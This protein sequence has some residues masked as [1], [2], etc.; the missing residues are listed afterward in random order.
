M[1][2]RS[3]TMTAIAALMIFQR[4]VYAGPTGGTV[5]AGSA[6]I[7]QSGSTTNVNQSS[8][9]AIINWQTFS[10]GKQETVNFLQPNSSAVA[11]NRVNGNEQSIIS[12]ALNANGRV[13]IVNSAGVLFSKGAQVNVGGLVASTLDISNSDFMAGNYKFSGTSAASVINRGN[14]HAS[15]GGYVALLGKT[16]ANDGVISARLGTVAMAAGEQMTLN[17]GGNSLFDVTIDK[18]TLNA[19][20]ANHRAIKADGGTVIMTAKAADE[21]LSAQV[22][23]TGIVQARTIASLLGG[24]SSNPK[25]HIGKIKIVAD[26]GTANISGKLDASAP[27]GGNGGTIE[28]SGSHVKIADAAIITTKASYGTSGSWLIDPTDFTIAAS[29]GDI[30]GAAL[31][32]QLDNNATVTIASTQGSS[33]TNGDINVNEA[34][35]W[36]SNAILTLNAANNININ[37]PITATGTSAG[38]ALNYGGTNGVVGATPLAGSDYNIVT[39]ASFSGTVLDSAGNPIA[40]PDTSGGVYG[41]ITLSGGSST[42]SVNGTGYTMIRSMADLAAVSSAQNKRLALAMD[43]NAAGTT[44]NYNVVPTLGAGSVFAGLGHTIDGLTIRGTTGTSS[45][46]AG[47]FGTVRSSTLRD[48]GLTNVDINVT[49]SLANAGG[50]TS[51]GALAGN[52]AL[53]GSTPNVAKDVYATGSITT[54]GVLGTSGGFGNAGGLFGQFAGNPNTGVVSTITDAFAMVNVAGY[55]GGTAGGI[56]GRANSVL[57]T[58]ID[59]TGV[60]PVTQL[61]LSVS[62]NGAGGLFGTLTGSV[63]NSYSTLTVSGGSGGGLINQYTPFDAGGT[64]ANSFATGNVTGQI[65]NGGLIGSISFGSPN[66]PPGG[67]ATLNN[68]YA[69]GNVHANSPTSQAGT[70]GEGGLVGAATGGA[71]GHLTVTNAHATGSVTVDGNGGADVGVG[72]LFGVIT[73]SQ[74]GSTISN[75]Y[76]ENSTTGVS[77]VNTSGVGGL[78]GRTDGV[79]IS[80][81][82]AT[83]NVVGKDVVGGLVGQFTG[84]GPNH[85]IVAS[86]TSSYSTATVT[87]TNPDPHSPE[88]GALV[89]GA[90]V[91]NI[92]SDVFYNQGTAGGVGIGNSA[93]FGGTVTNNSQGLTA[94]QLP[95]AAFY[96]NG[97]IGA[98]LAQRAEA[99]A[100]QAAAAAAQQ[101]AFQATATQASRTGSVIA[102]TSPALSAAAGAD[103]GAASAGT[104]S[105]SLGSQQIDNNIQYDN[106]SDNRDR[107]RRRT[108]NNRRPASGGGVG[109]TIRSIEINGQRFN[110][111]GGNSGN[112]TP[113]N[114][115]TPTQP[116]Q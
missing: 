98:V 111:R 91:A 78:V 79:D 54:T 58:R 106:R 96:A 29:G 8:Q 85:D 11:L 61:P 87:A 31:G 10:I 83:G 52:V 2:A 66:T 20:V 4:P 68:V 90:S 93:F 74:S 24:S 47:L 89:G 84:G 113:N 16:V 81:S 77:A 23:N 35:S 41:S 37:A 105:T 14:I 44:Y 69:T 95:D 36:S 75:S 82:H 116:V 88:V 103:I 51:V 22:N 67:N 27:K 48:I 76:Y 108:A 30:T 57:A 50:V 21:V 92:G 100:Q 42:F 53:T 65:N 73:D 28:T 39:P 64:V 97:T 80:G 104:A 70:F 12:G 107:N 25:V 43:L 1:R 56:S 109:A 34:V 6:G 32:A 45:Q 19:L 26:G 17:F 94:S 112:T 60:D 5:V 63:L 71:S 15:P 38:I 40:K 59:T 101:A 72:G 115:N 86:I 3:A 46:T 7:S 55:A 102:T 62:G 114:N 99:A 18:G 110:L 13:F 49:L 9:S 33:G